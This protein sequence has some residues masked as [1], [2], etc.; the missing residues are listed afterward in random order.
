MVGGGFSRSRV[1]EGGTAELERA[2][3]EKG[4]LESY[5]RRPVG[6]LRRPAEGRGCGRAVQRQADRKSVV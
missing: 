2:G 3:R 5:T 4:S 6:A 1:E